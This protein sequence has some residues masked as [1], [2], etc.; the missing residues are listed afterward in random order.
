MAGFVSLV[1]QGE[2]ARPAADRSA[3][4][5]NSI[6]YVLR[7]GCQWRLMPSDFPNWKTVY[8]VFRRWRRAGVATGSRPP[9]R[10]GAPQCR[11][12]ERAVGGDCRQSVGAHGRRGRF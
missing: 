2:K 7:T 4:M 6:L 11:Q 12:E 1:A 10:E 5:L 8:T 3:L 9:A